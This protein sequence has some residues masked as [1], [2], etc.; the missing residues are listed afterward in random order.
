MLQF[1]GLIIS[2]VKKNTGP[3]INDLQ[4]MGSLN[5]HKDLRA[6]T[7]VNPQVPHQAQPARRYAEAT[8]R[9]STERKALITI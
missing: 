2:I 8:A 3:I 9:G 1:K 6:E 7:R 4:R 5:I